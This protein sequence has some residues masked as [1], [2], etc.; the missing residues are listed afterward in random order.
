MFYNV[1]DNF[2]FKYP[3][4]GCDSIQETYSQCWQDIFILT[5]LNGKSNGSYL[6]VGAGDPDF[7]NNTFLLQ[8]YFNWQ[9][10][11]IDILDELKEKWQL[12]RPNACF[13]KEN[14]LTL[15]Y[16]SLLKS[17]FESNVIDYLQLDIE[18]SYN[19]LTALKKI[20]LTEYRFSIITF[21]TDLYAGG[22]GPAVRQESREILSNLG[23]TLI[24]G[25]VL[26]CGRHP[27]EDWW[28][29]L[30]LVNK[31]IALDIQQKSSNIKYPFDLLLY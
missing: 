22:S 30:N 12:C 18:P 21:E 2:N 29:D 7:I 28:V 14:A 5:L 11:S 27:Y 4:V 15:D 20:P 16:S 26:E 13:I 10:I 6:E 9:G 24:I 31:D 8:K 17:N 19:T 3:F 23:Y 25:D 1:W